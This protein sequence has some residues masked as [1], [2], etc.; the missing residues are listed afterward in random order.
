M[1]KL[2]YFGGLA[3]YHSVSKAKNCGLSPRIGSTETGSIAA[4]SSILER[5][6]QRRRDLSRE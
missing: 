5:E 2:Y 4:F 1:E 6:L 3:G